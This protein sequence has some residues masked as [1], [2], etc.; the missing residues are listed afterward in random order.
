MHLEQLY[1]RVNTLRLEQTS[2]FTVNHRHLSGWR[3]YRV[4]LLW[5]T[6]V[7]SMTEKRTA[8]QSE[9]PKILK[10]FTCKST[11]VGH[12]GS[13]KQSVVERR[14]DTTAAMLMA[15][16][17]KMSLK[18]PTSSPRFIYVQFTKCA[19]SLGDADCLHGHDLPVPIPEPSR[20]LQGWTSSIHIKVETISLLIQRRGTI[21]K[22]Q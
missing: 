12:L 8:E 3:R 19:G 16:D 7:I 20:D 17:F 15:S 10:H 1:F 6:Q 13:I 5:V 22:I 11:A 9:K 14:G 2:F 21:L 18:F 4:W